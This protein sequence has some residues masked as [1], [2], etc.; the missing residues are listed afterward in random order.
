MIVSII[1][2]VIIGDATPIEKYYT[3]KTVSKTVLVKT[4]KNVPQRKVPKPPSMST[5]NNPIESEYEWITKTIDTTIKV[6]LEKEEYLF[7]AK[8]G[9]AYKNEYF[10]LKNAFIYGILIFLILIGTLFYAEVMSHKK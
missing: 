6:G 3:H 10:N 2:G 9:A 1:I 8:F 7:Q 4:K 5:N